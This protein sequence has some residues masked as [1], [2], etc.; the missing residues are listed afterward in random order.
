[1]FCSDHEQQGH[2]GNDPLRRLLLGLE[3][4]GPHV[5]GASHPRL[6]HR[7]LVHV[8][9]LL[10]VHGNGLD[11]DNGHGGGE[12][13]QVGLLDES[14]ARVPA[15]PLHEEAMD[16]GPL[17]RGAAEILPVL[18]GHVALETHLVQRPL[19]LAGHGL[20]DGGEEGLGVEEATQPDA[21]GHVEVGHPALQLLDAEEE[22]GEP[23]REA[24][25]RGVGT[26]GPGVGHLVQ[27]EGGLQLFHVRSDGQLT[28]QAKGDSECI[29]KIG[30]IASHY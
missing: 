27:K 13:L 24:G 8:L 28:L 18:L 21:G 20:H 16:V 3:V 29:M 2:S 10:L 7:T 14:G 26:L 19:I 11:E 6:V 5:G 9:R 25:Q 17:S 30:V 22:V 15:R 23:D 12:V 1:M 4:E